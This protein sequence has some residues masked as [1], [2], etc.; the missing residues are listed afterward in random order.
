MSAMIVSMAGDAVVLTDSREHPEPRP[1]PG[2]VAPSWGACTI[3]GCRHDPC[4]A[5]LRAWASY[6]Q[7]YVCQEP[8]LPAPRLPA[9]RR[10]EEDRQPFGVPYRGP[11][12]P[13]HV[14]D[15]DGKPLDPAMVAVQD[16]EGQWRMWPMGDPDD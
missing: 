11:A 3:T 14:V 8:E 4:P 10:A 16:G 13:Q 7:R 2:A 1:V 5:K 12:L 9:R 15:M 6:G